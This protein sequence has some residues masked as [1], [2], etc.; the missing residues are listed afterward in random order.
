MVGAHNFRLQL[1]RAFWY[2]LSN[3]HVEESV[4]L[5][6]IYIK[7]AYLLPFKAGDDILGLCYSSLLLGLGVFGMYTIAL[8]VR[9][10]VYVCK[11]KHVNCANGLA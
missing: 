9:V 6:I 10:H 1:S 2:R 4:K 3:L 11:I 5:K 7:F 8:R